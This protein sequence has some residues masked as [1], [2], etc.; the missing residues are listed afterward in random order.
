M[1]DFKETCIWMSYRYAIGRKSIVSV[2]HAE[3]IAKHLDWIHPERRE[4][5]AKDIIK[6]IND[7]IN[8]YKNIHYTSY[9]NE[10]H[11]VFSIIFEWYLKY[12]Q[13]N[14]V[15]HFVEHEW[16]IDIDNNRVVEIKDR[17]DP[18]QARD[19]YYYI[20]N[21]FNDYSDYVGWV[22]LALMLFNR[23]KQ[24]TLEF[25]GKTEIKE[26][27]EWYDCT[28]WGNEIKIQKKYSEVGS[29][30]KWYFAPEYI[31]DVK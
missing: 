29:F 2:T 31:K 5:T 25:D 27:Y 16:Y 20:E 17:E 1:S 9:R 30:P 7:K 26:A 6:E 14:K 11:D 8:W 28:C 3:D 4:F 24:I 15:K 23:T 22:N 21:I 18:P 12:P 13:E 10:D 19:G